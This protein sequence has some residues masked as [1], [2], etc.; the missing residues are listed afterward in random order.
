VLA[1]TLGTLVVH[2]CHHPCPLVVHLHH[3]LGPLDVHVTITL[4]LLLFVFVIALVLLLFVFAL[5]L[6]LLLFM[7]SIVLVLVLF[8]VCDHLSLVLFLIMM[9]F[10]NA[11]VLG[12]T[13]MEELSVQP[14]EVIH[15]SELEL[16]VGCCGFASISSVVANTTATENSTTRD[17]KEPWQN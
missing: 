1:I 12:F 16:K 7:F 14:K 17:A 8:L 3:C 15:P 6:V 9:L 4:V 11:L 13:I 10:V 5:V 2:V